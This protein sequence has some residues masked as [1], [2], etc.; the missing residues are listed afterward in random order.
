MKRYAR[1]TP[2]LQA[3]VMIEAWGPIK[4][5]ST[6]LE[7]SKICQLR[8]D[9]FRWWSNVLLHIPE[10]PSALLLA[11]HWLDGQGVTYRELVN[12]LYAGRILIDPEQPRFQKPSAWA[13]SSNGRSAGSQPDNRSSI[14]RT[15]TTSG[16]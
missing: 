9:A 16:L 3:T 1:R 5:R 12:G 4:A 2:L 14:L 7:A 6:A 10:K 15:A 11:T 13:V 8:A